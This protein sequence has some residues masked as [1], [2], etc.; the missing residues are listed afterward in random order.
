MLKLIF[1]R[2]GETVWNRE[3]R[4]QG[5]KDVRLS[6][7]G[8][9]QAEL[10]A[11]RFRGEKIDVIYSS[12]LSR[13][14]ETAKTIAKFHP[15]APVKIK[16]ELSERSHGVIEGLTLEEIK[17]KPKL[18]KLL[19]WEKMKSQDFKFPKGESKA[20]LKERVKNFL[21]D[22]TRSHRC[23]TLL[24]VCHGGVI[25]AA[26]E[27]LLRKSDTT[28]SDLH[29]KNASVTILTLKGKEA[30]LEVLNDTSHLQKENQ[31]R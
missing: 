28:L 10:L 24:V 27:I 2:H 3:E 14:L 9:K 20:E 15:K 31:N 18:R 11:E 26:L 13:A 29:F 4:L 12:N 8:K 7:L 16:R 21:E 30:K 17:A 5:R 23:G 25:R 1:V 6:V 22:I 19:D